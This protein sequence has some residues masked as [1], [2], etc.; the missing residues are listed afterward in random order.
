MEKFVDGI[1][2]HASESI[3]EL[4]LP[5]NVCSGYT[6][7]NKPGDSDR[8]LGLGEGIINLDTVSP[9]NKTVPLSIKTDKQQNGR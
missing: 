9:L 1:V 3:H 6:R 2:G 5:I 4:C 7:V 8:K